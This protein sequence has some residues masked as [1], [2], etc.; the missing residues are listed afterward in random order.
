MKNVSVDEAMKKGKWLCVFWPLIS[1]ILPIIIGVFLK[2]YYAESYILPIAGFITG[3]VLSFFIWGITSVRWK[4]WA[5]TH[6]RNI[7]ELHR[8]AVNEKL[9]WNHGSFFNRFEIKSTAQPMALERLETRFDEPE[10][11]YDDVTVPHSSYFYISKTT[12]YLKLGGGILAFGFGIYL[13]FNAETTKEKLIVYAAPA[14]AVMLIY[15][16]YKGLSNKKPVLVLDEEGVRLQKKG[17]MLWEDIYNIDVLIKDKEQVLSF[18]YNGEVI[19]LKLEDV[20][21]KAAELRKLIETYRARH[22]KNMP[23]TYEA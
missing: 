2:E 13:Y 23:T 7:H 17:L 14:V 11:F 12:M 1:F 6:V 18:Y 9:I 20:D 16:A 15:Q 8:R 10:E 4:I 3:L 19:E 5:Y 21:V 22:L